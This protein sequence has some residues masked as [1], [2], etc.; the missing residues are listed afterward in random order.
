MA[1][2][3]CLPRH[4]KEHRRP[5]PDPSTR[6]RD[7]TSGK[8]TVANYCDEVSEEIEKALP[9]RRRGAPVKPAELPELPPEGFPE[10]LD[11]I[12]EAQ[13]TELLGFCSA[14]LAVDRCFS[15]LE[16]IPEA[17]PPAELSAALDEL[18]THWVMSAWSMSKSNVLAI[19]GGIG[20]SLYHAVRW[21]LAI[22]TA[23]QDRAALQDLHCHIDQL[24]ETA[25]HFY[26]Q[27]I[28]R[29]APQG[30]GND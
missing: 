22:D 14:V 1:R 4:H 18:A 13:R 11:G 24:S 9:A 7:V 6:L 8:V 3:M 16:A 10:A 30:G 2:A 20:L 12:S 27:E 17:E 21:F 23:S 5:G 19:W 29:L 26:A 28:D 15:D 25:A